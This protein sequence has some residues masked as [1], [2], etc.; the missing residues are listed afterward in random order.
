MNTWWCGPS[1]FLVSRLQS[2]SADADLEQTSRPTDGDVEEQR[3]AVA[4]SEGLWSTTKHSRG[5]PSTQVVERA[6]MRPMMRSIFR[7]AVCAPEATSDCNFRGR[8]T[9]QFSVRECSK[10]NLAQQSNHQFLSNDMFTR[11]PCG[12]HLW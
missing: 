4:R 2:C 1:L 8:Q 7:G 3:G 10:T 12:T 6:G 9:L 5:T 11:H